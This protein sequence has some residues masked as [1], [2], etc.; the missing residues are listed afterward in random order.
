MRLNCAKCFGWQF[1]HDKNENVVSEKKPNHKNPKPLI[2]IQI[3]IPSFRSILSWILSLLVLIYTIPFISNLILYFHREHI[4]SFRCCRV[5]HILPCSST[6]FCWRR[7]KNE[8]PN[9]CS[10]KSGKRTDFHVDCD[11]WFEW[12]FWKIPHRDV[13]LNEIK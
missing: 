2:N 6:Q 8:P 7:K 5:L 13:L 11:S 1:S 3:I 10:K 4:N 12:S 9:I